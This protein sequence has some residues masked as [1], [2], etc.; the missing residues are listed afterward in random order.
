MQQRAIMETLTYS[1]ARAHLG[2]TIER[3]V[4]GHMPIMIQYSHSEPVVM[5]S[6]SDFESYE[7][8]AYLMKS[9]KN[10]AKLIEAKNEIEA[11]ILKRKQQYA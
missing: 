11:L 2:A 7:E 6:L 8:T 5:M 10:R 4:Q 1:A 3:V 9:P